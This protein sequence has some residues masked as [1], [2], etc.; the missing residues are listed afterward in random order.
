MSVGNNI[1]VWDAIAKSFD[2]TR[3]K[4]WKECI[5][6]IERLPRESTVADIG[7]GNGRHLIYCAEHCSKAIGVDIS[8]N[9]LK[10]AKGKIQNME[11]VELV[12]ADVLSLPFMDN[13][14]DHI[15]FIATLHNIHGRENRLKA[16]SEIKRVLKPSG[17]ALI[18]VWSRWQERFLVHFLKKLIFL[19]RN[20]EFGDIE[21]M[22]KKNGL[23]IPRFYHLYSKREFKSDLKKAGFSLKEIYSTKIASKRLRD[24]HFAIVEKVN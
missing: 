20:K 19:E 21:I 15:L 10:I 12:N 23:S 11:N 13:S 14:I 7:C 16:L 24:N 18:S 6:F 4:P 9:L 8:I 2:E 22:W 1:K 17:T 5:E 3:K